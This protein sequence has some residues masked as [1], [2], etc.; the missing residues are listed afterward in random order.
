MANFIDLKTISAILTHPTWDLLLI[1]FFIAAGFFYGIASGR[2][3]LIATLVSVYI[4]GLLFENFSYL[5]SF[6]KGRPLLEVFLFRGF[7]FIVLILLLAVLFNRLLSRDNTPG[8]RRWW[9]IFLLS[10]L[11]VGLFMSFIFQLLP[12]KELFDFS[13]IVQNIFASDRAFF[14]WL[15]LPLVALFL[16][17]KR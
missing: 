1:L 13:P 3:K 6:V 9:Q 8:T 15:T 2:T 12:A 17:R 11:E 10:F 4:A 14:W 16:V 7:I 5:N